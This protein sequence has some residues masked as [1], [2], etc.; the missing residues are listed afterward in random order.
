M[1][2][3]FME[4]GGPFAAQIDLGESGACREKDCDGE[5]L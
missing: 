2:Q 3:V 5:S 1:L 4:R